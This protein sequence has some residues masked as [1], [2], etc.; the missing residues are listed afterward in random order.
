MPKISFIAHDGTHTTV[1]AEPGL[2][3]MQVATDNSIQGIDGDCGGQCACATCHVF[4]S[5]P[6]NALIP[7]PE[8]NEDEMLNFTA[9]RQ[10]ASRL[11]CQIK[12]TQSLDGI[13]VH[14]PIGQH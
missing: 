9:E 6:W 7:A 8:A 10:G 11:A 2:S 4:I 3:L 1:D 14:M 5:E 12:V 13:N